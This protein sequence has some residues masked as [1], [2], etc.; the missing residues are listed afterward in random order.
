MGKS[1]SL[2]LVQGA[3]LTATSVFGQTATDQSLIREHSLQQRTQRFGA[4]LQSSE[5]IKKLATTFV[6][7]T[8]KSVNSI[9]RKTPQPVY[10]PGWSVDFN[11]ADQWDQFIT[12]D[13]NG[14]K[15]AD[16][17]KKN[18]IWSL[19]LNDGNGMAMYYYNAKNT[20][21]DWLISPGINLKGG[22]TYYVNFKLRCVQAT[23]PERIEV[24]YGNA[25]TVEAMT[26]EILAPT[27]LNNTTFQSYTQV[28]KPTTD[29]V[30]H[31]GFH[32]ISDAFRIALYVDDVSVVAAPEA[33]SPSKVTNVTITP[34]ASAALKATVSFNAPSTAYDGSALTSLNGIRVL[35]NGT[36]V[37]DIKK[38]QPGEQHTFIVDNISQEGL[39]AFTF[40]PYNEKGDGESYVVSA[41][42]G[43]DVPS[44]PTNVMLSDDPNNIILSWDAATPA[45]NGAFFPNKITYRIHTV[46]YNN[47]GQP[48]LADEMD[49]VTDGKTQYA[50]GFGADEG[51]PRQLELAVTAENE[52]GRSEKGNISNTL[53]MGKPDRTPYHESF[54]NG[55]E[56]KVLL[57]FA[58]GQGVTFQMAGAGRTVDE[59]S[60]DDGGSLYLQTLMKDSVGVNTFKISLAGTQHPVLAFKLKN[61]TSTGT[62]Y[63]YA[64]VPGKGIVY[65]NKE[66]LVVGENKWITRKYDLSQFIGERYIQLG[67]ALADKSNDN[68]TKVMFI[69]NIHVGDL[70]DK[71]LAIAVSA[72]K[73]AMRSE[74]TNVRVK[75]SNVGDKQVDSY[76]LVLTVDGKKISEQQVNEPLASLEVKNFELP[77]KVESL[78]AKDMLEIVVT[79]VADG[80]T[81]TK[82]NSAKTNISVSSPDLS[83]VQNLSGT[84]VGNDVKLAWEKPSPLM[85]RTDDFESYAAWSISGIGNWT[86]VD[87]DEATTAGDFLYDSNGAEIPYTH[88]GDPFAF[89]VFNPQDYSGRNLS[90][91]GLHQFDAHS[92]IQSLASVH[93]TQMNIY[94]FD[95]E[96]A[97]NNDWII[98][99]ALPGDAQNI[100]FYANNVVATNQMTGQKV[101]LKQTVQI[102]YSTLDTDTTHFQVL[103][104]IEIAGGKWQ[105]VEAELPEGTK[106]FAIRNITSPETAYIL[107]IDD[108]TYHVGGGSAEK[109]NIYRD[110]TLFASTTD[111]NYIDT[112]APEG[113][114]TYQVTAVYEG[115]IESAPITISVVVTGIKHLSATEVRYDVYTLDGICVKYQSESLEGLKAGVYIINGKKTMIK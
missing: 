36:Q 13:A 24:K 74:T 46:S 113:N 110:G 42:I 1:L 101:D 38:L 52:K 19:L 66:Q 10:E 84:K 50:L 41:Y 85:A 62:F 20:A 78:E 107:L 114:H 27:E 31:I 6:K 64:T 90:A 104:T 93:G 23:Y 79:V 75:V 39:N 48:Q 63:V 57:P 56:E 58:E 99:P 22:K 77:Y 7:R 108:I 95:Q 5:T 91:G 72:N 30:Y 96:P 97:A 32:A 81:N 102:L 45:H 68:S 60:D 92:G 87:G 67:F 11:T 40:L 70:A 3:M 59:S 34:D 26:G 55:K 2:L 100:S 115:G 29:G 73:E 69:D 83:P 15:N 47:W 51:N 37:K 16:E 106:H 103:K 76:K 65:L 18:G 25:A 94:T 111:C 105:K 21:D 44:A 80:D 54:V 49:V 35:L 86:L 71:D 28:L 89:I 43:L 17:S 4:T 53:L 12:I 82:N 14:D 112:N 109:Y 9:A 8:H 98:S 88:E 33:D 61:S